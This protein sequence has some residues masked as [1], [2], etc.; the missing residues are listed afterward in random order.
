MAVA[1]AG[2][3]ACAGADAETVK[4][5]TAQA[6]CEISCVG[7]RVM[8][9]KVCGEEILFAPREW[10]HGGGFSH[11][12]I[13]ICWPW[14][15]KSGPE[16]SKGHGFAHSLRFEVRSRETAR[17]VLGARSSDETRNLWPYDFDL[18]YAIS[19]E[20]DVLTLSLETLNSSKEP[21]LI[22][23]GFHPY[24]SVGE[25]D[26]AVVKG[27]DGCLYCDARVSTSFDKAWKGDISVTDAFDHVFASPDGEYALIDGARNRR[28]SIAAKG[29]RRLVVWNP[30]AKYPAAESPEPGVLAVGD[31]RR[32]V[33]VEPATLWRDQGFVLEPGARN[34]LSAR[35]SASGL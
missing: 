21:F 18:K 9:F 16:G 2:V 20:G 8:S 5:E 25:R 1:M 29:N 22:T 13:P 7:A 12:G 31:W 23:S 30:G 28:I 14:F 3:A 4:L 19:L 6:T 32:F 10:R 35:I 34:V 27:V 15:G 11:G 17:V 33:C 24:F 26:K